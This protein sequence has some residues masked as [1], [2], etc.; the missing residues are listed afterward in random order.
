MG[1]YAPTTTE[2]FY[3]S[4]PK[5][6][7]HRHLE[8]TLRVTTLRELALEQGISLPVPITD[9]SA[10]V[11]IQPTDALN[12]AVFLSKFQTL[13]LFYRTPEIIARVTREA[14][15]DAHADGV[16]YLELRFTPLA[17]GR[18]RG[19]A[20][21]D[22]MDW[23]CDS[24]ADASKQYDLPVSLI[25]SVNRHESV[26]VAEQV[27]SLALERL[28]RGIVALDLAGNEA[29]FSALPFLDVFH[30][31]QVSGLRITVHAGEWS[32]PENVRS[33]IEDFQVDRVGHGVRIL[34]DP[35][36]VA[37]AR[38]RQTAFEV[39][40]TSNFQSGVVRAV[41]EHPIQRMLAQG[42]NVTANTDDP[43]ISQITLS[44]EYRLLVEELGFSRK[45]L[46]DRILAS[47][48]ASFLPG[49]DREALLDR[50]L[51]EF[52]VSQVGL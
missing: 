16:C 22:V 2:A 50:L 48:R 8:G 49:P 10:A 43:S 36:V 24:A 13:R 15:E 47:A 52:A 17:L 40:V 20:L 26:E 25:V 27:A 28:D 5:V 21:A 46:V 11:Q 12:S 39:C 51:V 41:R 45:M 31:A 18:A 44:D 14:I 30:A 37:L 35:A 32:G 4:L 9:L 23:V 7:L 29:D 34:E 1:W 3:R 19:F 33:A 6:D 42:L 38:E